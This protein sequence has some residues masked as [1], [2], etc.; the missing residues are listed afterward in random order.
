MSPRR[1]KTIKR[2]VVFLLRGNRSHLYG[3]GSGSRVNC[4]CTAKARGQPPTTAALPATSSMICA[5]GHSHEVLLHKHDHRPARRYPHGR[6]GRRTSAADEPGRSF[7]SQNGA[8]KLS[9]PARLLSIWAEPRWQMS[10]REKPVHWHSAPRFFIKRCTFSATSRKQQYV[11][12]SA[13]QT[14]R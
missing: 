3:G 14:P 2:L 10:I 12:S 5:C 9:G 1:T 8:D 13:C 7:N 6:A 11:S 4:V